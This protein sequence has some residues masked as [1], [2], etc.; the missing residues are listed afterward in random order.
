MSI[1]LL[2]SAAHISYSLYYIFSV[3]K[4]PGLTVALS[5]PL[6]WRWHSL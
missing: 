5:A 6:P 3:V 2:N 1:A 4:I